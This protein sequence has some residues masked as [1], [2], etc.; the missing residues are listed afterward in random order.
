MGTRELIQPP[1]STVRFGL[2]PTPYYKGEFMEVKRSDGTITI[3]RIHSQ[4]GMDFEI[5]FPFAAAKNQTEVL[6][7][8]QIFKSLE[9]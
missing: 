9:A 5:N 7:S 6:F 2:E 3:G 1:D 8:A 4:V